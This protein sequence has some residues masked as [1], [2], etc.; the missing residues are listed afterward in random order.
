MAFL[1]EET[2]HF[3]REKL[4]GFIFGVKDPFHY[5]LMTFFHY[6]VQLSSHYLL[7][8][9]YFY[10][11]KA[12]K[13]HLQL[14]FP[15]KPL[16]NN[17]EQC[18]P[19]GFLDVNLPQLPPFREPSTRQPSSDARY[20][21]LNS[22]QLAPYLGSSTPAALYTEPRSLAIAVPLPLLP[23]RCVCVCVCV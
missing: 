1:R 9:F 13:D 19:Q 18:F 23:R 10:S 6:S 17:S 12:S 16:F 2:K 4:K 15:W 5:R 3:V 14:V 22:P 21:H 7:P 11:P 8:F 20:Q